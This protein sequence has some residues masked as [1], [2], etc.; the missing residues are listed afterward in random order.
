VGD[1]KTSNH[2][3]GI[4]TTTTDHLART[5]APSDVCFDPNKKVT[6]PFP[7][8]VPTKR[9]TEHSS[10]KSQITEGLVVR[11][12]DAIGPDSDAAHG[13]SGGGIVS[14]TYRKEARCIK[15]S[16]D[17]FVENKLIARATD[18]TTQNHGNTSGAITEPTAD[19]LLAALEA[20]KLARCTLNELKA[21]CTDNGRED[22]NGLLEVV[23]GDSVKLTAK[24]VNATEPGQGAVCPPPPGSHLKTKFVLVRTGKL[25]EKKDTKVGVDEITLSAADWI[26]QATAKKDPH[27]TQVKKNE[28]KFSADQ[29]K[30][31]RADGKGEVKTTKVAD[32]AKDKDLGQ[33]GEG[34]GWFPGRKD[35]KGNAWKPDPTLQWKEKGLPPPATVDGDKLKTNNEARTQSQIDRQN[36]RNGASMTDAQRA[37]IADARAQDARNRELLQMR[38]DAAG[39][40]D[41]LAKNNKAQEDKEMNRKAIAGSVERAALR[42]YASLD[43]LKAAFNGGDA[44]TIQVAAFGCVG[45]KTLMIK[46]YPDQ[47]YEVDLMAVGE[48]VAALSTFRATVAIFENF[49]NLAGKDTLK[50]T[51]FAQPVSKLKWQFV[52]LLHDSSKNQRRTKNT[53][54]A[55]WSIELGFDPLVSAAANFAM[56]V[57]DFAGPAGRLAG[58]ILQKVVNAEIGCEIAV[59][60]GFLVKGSLDEYWESPQ[61]SPKFTASVSVKLYVKFVIGVKR[62]RDNTVHSGPGAELTVSSKITFPVTLDNFKITTQ[63]LSFDLAKPPAGKGIVWSWEASVKV[64]V[65]GFWE[66]DKSLSGIFNEWSYDKKTFGPWPG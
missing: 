45:A 23:Y 27:A 36:Y 4:A 66:T 46:T 39:A 9:A 58:W 34:K 15:G 31:E 52:E 65:W 38:K 1:T 13:F 35:D 32:V 55:K 10:Q 16:P 50:I 62:E 17:V 22:R 51:L 7:N 14:G 24:R 60:F 8:Q 47:E 61:V 12:G 20:R 6:A 48:I 11:V 54:G 2:K 49:C 21:V 59:S 40:Y 43:A 29:K 19:G 37:Q 44:S 5:L 63:G 30:Y 28:D 41:D 57:Y 25:P 26:G 64:D 33:T 42:T 53:V 3:L 18:P 56:P